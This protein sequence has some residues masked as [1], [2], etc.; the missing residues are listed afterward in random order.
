MAFPTDSLDPATNAV[1]RVRLL[2]GD[3]D[4]GDVEFVEQLYIYF[5]DSNAQDENLSAIQALKALVAKYAKA[6]DEVVGDV[7]ITL[8]QRY[9][10]YKD[11]LDTYLKDPAFGFLGTIQPYA[12]GLSYSE[13]RT[14]QLNTDLRGVSFSVGSS[15]NRGQLGYDAA[16]YKSNN[17][18]FE[19]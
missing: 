8:K 15:K 19:I 17:G 18:L 2:V 11:L 16:Y 3:V 5:L 14:D 9:E 13:G 10:G 7:Q 4:P 6:M 1:D 12:G